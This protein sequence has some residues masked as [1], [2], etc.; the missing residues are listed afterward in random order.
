MRYTIFLIIARM[1]GNKLSASYTKLFATGAGWFRSSGPSPSG[2]RLGNF[3]LMLDQQR[4][5]VMTNAQTA[6]RA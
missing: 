6:V 1:R 3:G 4:W 5:L 2:S